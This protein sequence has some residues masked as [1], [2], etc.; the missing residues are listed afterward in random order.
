MNAGALRGLRRRY[1]DATLRI[2]TAPIK[3]AGHLA[4]SECRRPLI[5]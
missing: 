5:N 3:T 1:K 4:S 2:L